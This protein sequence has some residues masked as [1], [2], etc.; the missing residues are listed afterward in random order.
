[1]EKKFINGLPSLFVHKIREVLWNPKGIIDYNNLTY[2]DIIITI[3]RE[4][5]EMCIHMKISKQATN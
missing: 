4:G 3:Q 5:I 2:G 1:M